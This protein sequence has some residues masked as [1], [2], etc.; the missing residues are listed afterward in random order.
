MVGKNLSP[1][2]D[3]C[4]DDIA[5]LHDGQQRTSLVKLTFPL[6]NKERFFLLLFLIFSIL[7]SS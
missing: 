4:D 2:K 6:T 1:P 3:R 7:S 5:A